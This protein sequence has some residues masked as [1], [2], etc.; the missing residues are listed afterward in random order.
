MKKLLSIIFALPSIPRFLVM[1]MVYIP[2]CISFVR[3]YGLNGAKYFIEEHVDYE[4]EVQEYFRASEVG[5]FYK[6]E[7]VV[8]AV[9]DIL[10]IVLLII[11]LTK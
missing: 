2:I 8:D 11:V 6:Y 1:L 10:F 4:R 9:Y 7:K 3:K 5:S